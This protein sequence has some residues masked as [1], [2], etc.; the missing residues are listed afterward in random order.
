MLAA[1]V[2]SCDQERLNAW[3][4][5][6]SD[7]NEIGSS[8][9]VCWIDKYIMTYLPLLDL[10]HWRSEPYFDSTTK[11]FSFKIEESY[12]SFWFMKMP[13][14][15]FAKKGSKIRVHLFDAGT[16]HSTSIRIKD[17]F[18][19][20]DS[21]LD[22]IDIPTKIAET[23]T[24]IC[25]VRNEVAM[26]YAVLPCYGKGAPHRRNPSGVRTS[27]AKVDSKVIMV[28]FRR[29][30][31]SDLPTD[32]EKCVMP[33]TDMKYHPIRMRFY[34][35]S[36]FSP[37]R[38]LLHHEDEIVSPILDRKCV[39]WD[40]G[41]GRDG[42]WNTHGCNTILSEQTSTLC[43][44]DS[45]GIFA[46]VAEMVEE[47][48][49]KPER[50]W[51]LVVKIAGYVVSMTLLLIFFFVIGF[52]RHLWDMFHLIRWNTSFAYLLALT[53]LI[54]SELEAVR[55]HRHSNAAIASL[56]LYF[57][58]AIIA[59][60]LMEAIAYFRAITNGIIGGHTKQYVCLGWG[61]P[62][63]LLGYIWYR[64]GLDIGTDPRCFIG[65]ENETKYP[66]FVY[67]YT[68]CGVSNSEDV[69]NK[70][71][72][73]FLVLSACLHLLNYH[74]PKHHN[75]CDKKGQ[76]CGGVDIPRVGVGNGRC[77]LLT[78]NN[79]WIS[80]SNSNARY[81]NEGFHGHLWNI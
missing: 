77:P 17:W 16:T 4:E 55:I 57:Y 60:H 1:K 49:V 34:H 67:T 38:K 78:G 36:K 68:G 79:F 51:L 52:S 23:N 65:W 8:D 43:E 54:V 74:R 2:V 53:F 41:I 75:P 58:S 48:Y 76:C 81:R 3:N 15:R 32:D 7:P 18:E 50:Q 71:E 45:P 14:D 62:M 29:V 13:S 11:E 59:F 69:L 25:K 9:L 37:T 21:P 63:I 80:C 27:D 24:S 66:Y 47:R 22:T 19:E 42:A 12:G 35:I 72:S 10:S 40:Q 56:S 6:N 30:E 26:Y 28:N 64:H 44:C 5:V 20:I 46:I 61:L 70:K 39:R 31:G 33:S 73:P